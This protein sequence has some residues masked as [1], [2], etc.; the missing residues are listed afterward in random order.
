MKIKK[1]KFVERF[2]DN[3]PPVDCNY[4]RGIMAYCDD[5]ILFNIDYHPK[6]NKFDDKTC[7]I[8]RSN[9]FPSEFL[10]DTI[11]DK[12]FLNKNDAINKTQEIFENTI[13]KFLIIKE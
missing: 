4:W 9:Y 5:M 11:D 10:F 6:K 13:H 7:F 3:E 12:V 1:L 8:I 2:I